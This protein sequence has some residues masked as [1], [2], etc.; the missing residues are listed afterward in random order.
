VLVDPD[1]RPLAWPARPTWQARAACIGLGPDLFFPERGELT[2]DA[3]AVCARCP[4]SAECREYALSTA[5]KFGIWGGTS[6]RARRVERVARNK[7]IAA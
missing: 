2:A 5:E 7:E 4:V 1:E 6:E 3:R